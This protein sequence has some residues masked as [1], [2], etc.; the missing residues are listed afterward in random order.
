MVAG[1]D[2]LRM[3]LHSE[4]ELLSRY[5]G[6]EFAVLLPGV[7][8]EAAIAAAEALRLRVAGALI[9]VRG[10]RIAMTCSVGVCSMT[11]AQSARPDI[12]V[13]RADQ[14]LY[15]AKRAGRNRVVSFDTNTVTEGIEES[16]RKAL[17]R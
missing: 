3:G 13:R 8:E 15:I 5:G 6:E 16:I 7:H 10:K 9:E 17:H 11:A 4:D 1:S 2:A 14:A 12:A